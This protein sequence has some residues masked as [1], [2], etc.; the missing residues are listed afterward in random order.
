MSIKLT[1]DSPA[2]VVIQPKVEIANAS[3]FEIALYM[4]SKGDL[5]APANPGIEPEKIGEEYIVDLDVIAKGQSLRLKNVLR[6]DQVTL[7]GILDGKDGSENK[8]FA[9]LEATLSS[10]D[11]NL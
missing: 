4:E 5:F 3:D 2:T 9:I 1:L 10:G 6:N 11:Y 7:A 8:Q